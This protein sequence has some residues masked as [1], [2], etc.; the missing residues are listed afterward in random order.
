MQSLHG[1]GS[2]VLLKAELQELASP[3]PTFTPRDDRA[4]GGGSHLPSDR[5]CPTWMP[6]TQGC[7]REVGAAG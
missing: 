4:S 5:P 7:G 2:R 3:V 1:V 6:D